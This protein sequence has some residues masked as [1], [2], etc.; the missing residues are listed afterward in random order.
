MQV[1]HG[2]PAE[3]FPKVWK[4]WGITKLCFEVDTEPYAQQ[5]D[6]HISELAKKQGEDQLCCLVS[7]A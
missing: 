3:L 1:L 7:A 4:D 6:K 5:R 2:K